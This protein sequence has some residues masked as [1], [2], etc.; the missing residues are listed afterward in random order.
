MTNP[1]SARIILVDHETA[2]GGKFAK[3][4]S[5]KVVLDFRWAHKALREG[6]YASERDDWGGF[7][8]LPD[9]HE[10]EQEPSM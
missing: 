5:E 1:A 4:W 6:V 3:D 9:E 2:E 10:A 8:A 7:R